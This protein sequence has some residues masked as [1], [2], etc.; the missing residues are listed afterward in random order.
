MNS[1]HQHTNS[2][3]G[4][5]YKITNFFI[6]RTRLTSLA[7]MLIAV[8]GLFSILFNQLSGFPSVEI[9]LALVQSSY[10]GASNEKVLEEVTR[11]I[12]N[13]IKDLD[14][15]KAFSSVSTGSFSNITVNI[16]ENATSSEV[17]SQ[18]QAAIDGVSFPDGVDSKV[19]TPSTGGIDFIY[20]IVSSDID[21]LY[22]TQDQFTRQLSS[23]SGTGQVSPILDLSNRLVIVPKQ[24]KMTENRLTVNDL[25]KAVASI[26][27]S[28][29]IGFN[30]QV[31]D[32]SQSI[33]VQYSNE[34]EAI[35]TL[36]NILIPLPQ[37]PNLNVTPTP[38]SNP[39][40]PTETTTPRSVKLSDVAS[41]ENDY[42]FNSDGRAA[43][44]FSFFAYP[45]L[46][47]ASTQTLTLQVKTSSGTNLA[48]YQEQVLEIANSLENTD[49]RINS[50]LEGFEFNSDRNLIVQ[51]FSSSE[52]N[53]RQVD[54]VIGGLVG[55]KI[56]DQWW[57]YFGFLL[58]ALQLVFLVML[59]FVSWRSAL[60]ATVAIPMSIVFS[61][62]YILAIGEQL[63][64]LVLFSLV[65]VIGLVVD[66]TLVV[67]ESIQ[68][69]LD[70]GYKGKEAALEAIKDIGDGLFSSTLT[71]VIV[72]IP[73]AIISGFIGQI[74]AY[75]P[76]TVI[77]A[78]IGSYIVAI[79][80]L[81]WL[82]SMFLKPNPNAKLDEESN[83]WVIARWLINVNSRI[84]QSPRLVRLFIIALLVVIPLSI[85]GYLF[86]TEQVTSVQFAREQNS[87]VAQLSL[88]Y[89]PTA[90]LS[91]REQATIQALEYINN[92][93]GIKDITPYPTQGNGDVAFY[94]N[95]LPRNQRG[96]NSD[97]NTIDW[98]ANWNQDL[99]DKLQA[100]DPSPI[101]D[102]NAS[103]ISA[104]PPT[105]S[106]QVTVAVVEDDPQLLQDAS[107]EIAE[108]LTQICKKGSAISVDTECKDGDRIVVK[109]DDGYTGKAGSVI[110]INLDRQKLIEQG[111]LSSS[112]FANG[113]GLDNTL[114][115]GSQLS[116]VVNEFTREVASV[117]IADKSTSVV[118]RQLEN[119]DLV[120]QD[121]LEARIINPNNPTKPVAISDIAN[122]NQTLSKS[123]IQRLDG[124]TV[125]Q[126]QA[127]LVSKY[128]ANPQIAGQVTNAIVDYYNDNG[129]DKAI[130]LGL[131]AGSVIQY[132][133]GDTA[134]IGRSFAELG[135]ALV[136]AIFLIYAI[137]VIFFNSFTMPFAI[138]FT[139]PLTF[140]G[141]FPAVAFLA[142]GEF[143]F[144]EIL[145]IIILTGLVVNVA[146]YL[147]DAGNQKIKEGWDE[148][149]AIAYASGLRLR[150][151]FLTTITAIASLAPLAITSPFYRSIAVTII[152]GLIS[153]GLVSLITTPILFIFFRWSS[154]NYHN[155]TWYNKVLSV[156]LFP[157]Y[158]IYWGVRDSYIE[159]RVIW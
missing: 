154:K 21:Q 80:F 102:I 38:P 12:E 116:T 51:S 73:F 149:K 14:G 23:L 11:P 26:N 152:F 8:I 30:T 36:E 78:I 122:V 128:Q 92:Q 40:L 47:F 20:N 93:E 119:T 143:G 13:A 138:L 4:F 117:S 74:F 34:N 130:Q 118:I 79:V 157:I 131:Q 88:T 69:K 115:V 10:P 150:A 39:S 55:S 44:V 151:V 77:P 121:I 109:V 132:S 96:A 101:L 63:N 35:A 145:G 100:I 46:D 72:F 106:F 129:S 42:F 140:V 127:R 57:G 45:G 60:I 98:V 56:G 82:G 43:N 76:A 125:N 95:L 112:L 37:L 87:N 89:A 108:T 104:G 64:F 99:R 65:L 32:L 22:K 97:I 123:L 91:Q 50:E 66:P 84:L 33:I 141:V 52:E 124:Q 111:L 134:A 19:I 24:E 68:R 67:L 133:E 53:A 27:N 86:G 2:N 6:H 15:V 142:G 81:S 25:E 126:I 147:I 158:W 75:I 103:S 83:L 120:T 28:L 90:T 58:G 114:L 41:I 49:F 31:D 29:P 7:F 61:T 48:Q 153:S 3:T 156:P 159:K 54:Q 105:P 9:K 110:E 136:L 113:S 155:S 148:K 18:I 62:I 144:L 5:N 71:N 1:N 85:A 70:S 137:L 94:I 59:V 135:V 107:L 17:R 16:E 139:I 146:I